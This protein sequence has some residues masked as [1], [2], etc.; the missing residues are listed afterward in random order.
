MFR[1]PPEYI[2]GLSKKKYEER[3]R[4]IVPQWV[5]TLD[6]ESSKALLNVCCKLGLKLH[7]E[8]LT[9]TEKQY[10]AESIWSDKPCFR[11]DQPAKPTKTP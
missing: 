7:P 11:L 3:F 2:W 1:P 4:R 9:G 6:R 10:G 5:L 8:V